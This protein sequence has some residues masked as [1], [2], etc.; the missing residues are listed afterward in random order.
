MLLT[1]IAIAL[2]GTSILLAAPAGAAEPNLAAMLS[3]TCAGCH[4]TN[5]ASMGPSMPVIAGQ[6]KEYLSETL[7][8]FK[9]GERPSSIM[10]RL[11]KAYSEEDIKLMAEFYASH[12]FVRQKQEVDAGKVALGKQLHNERCKK[13]HID[14]G[15]DSEDGGILAGQWK[16]YLAISLNEFRASARSM[17]RKMAE[18]I[19]GEE[20]LTPE[21]I[22]ALVDFYASQQ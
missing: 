13:C 7:K 9:N 20:P 11:M 21:D 4:G 18:K 2:M 10:G 17:P 15:H 14:N 6:P 8:K 5:G 19:N 22:Q 3:N 12:P 1:R 16:Q